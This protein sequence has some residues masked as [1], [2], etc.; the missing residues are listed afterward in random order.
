MEDIKLTLKSL[1][2]MPVS[3]QVLDDCVQIR[4]T[5]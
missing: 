5:D 4:Q 3:G 1:K 2:Q